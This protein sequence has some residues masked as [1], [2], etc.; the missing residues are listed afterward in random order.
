V[1]QFYT[2]L[3]ILLF[4]NLQATAQRR[5]HSQFWQERPGT[6]RV[7]LETGPTR[8][9]GDMSEEKDIFKRPRLGG[10]VGG[11][12]S[13]R[14]TPWLTARADGR[15]YFI[16]G[17]QQDTR[18]WYNNLSFL[19]L[20]PDLALTLQADLWPVDDPVHT[21]IPY[22]FLGAGVTYLNTITS[23]RGKLVSLPPLHT[24][25]VAY[26]R[27]PGV[28]RWGIGIPVKT[29]YRTLFA[30]EFS[31][32]HVTNDYLDDVS[33]TYPDFSQLSALGAALADRRADLGV[34][35]LQPNQPGNQRGNPTARDGYFAMTIR[36]TNLWTTIARQRYGR[37]RQA[38]RF[39]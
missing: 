30:V 31:Y 21:F 10:L 16:Y 15:F 6:W 11:S 5:Q 22:V 23:Y 13:Y 28:V 19:A 27:L 9:A 2:P 36:Y 17:K 12:V 38:P 20:N 25:G 14:F 8:Y 33:T 39:R 29:A 35:G 26:S 37:S 18:V 3:F 34:A 24:E 1:K 7:S 32:T 4:A